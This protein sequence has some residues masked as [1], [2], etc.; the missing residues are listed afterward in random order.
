MEQ[1]KHT[2]CDDCAIGHIE[3]KINEFK[4]DKID[5]LEFDCRKGYFTTDQILNLLP[6]ELGNKYL[7][8]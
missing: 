1:C 4:M 5:C 7:R 6:A 2:F 3:A 8:F